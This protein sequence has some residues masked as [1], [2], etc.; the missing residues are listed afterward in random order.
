LFSVSQPLF[1]QNI[2]NSLSYY[3]CWQQQSKEINSKFADGHTDQNHD[4]LQT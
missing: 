2:F 3:L 1:T 4:Q